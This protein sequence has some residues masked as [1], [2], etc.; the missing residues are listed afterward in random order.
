MRTLIPISGY[1]WF[2]SEFVDA[3]GPQLLPLRLAP[4][5]LGEATKVVNNALSVSTQYSDIRLW[6]CLMHDCLN[7][8]G[9][10]AER[11]D[12]TREGVLDYVSRNL[13]RITSLLSYLD[14][15]WRNDR[16][17]PSTLPPPDENE[18]TDEVLKCDASLWSFDEW[19]DIQRLMDDLL[20]GALKRGYIMPVPIVNP[21]GFTRDPDGLCLH[22]SE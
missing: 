18:P 15:K 5:Y 3:E 9:L 1:A 22:P 13:E 2:A 7:A 20:H 4:Y 16:H 6:L 17:L 14:R 21:K 19:E 8:A 10:G 12:Y 11:S